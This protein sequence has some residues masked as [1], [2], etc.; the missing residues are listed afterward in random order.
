MELV[1]I[2]IGEIVMTIILAG[3]FR[4]NTKTIKKIVENEELDKIANQ[5]PEN[6]E[7]CQ[8]ILKMLGNE[9]V[10]MKENENPDRQAS[11][12]IAVTDTIWIANIKESYTRIQTI[13]HECLHSIQNRK[14]LLFNFIYSNIYLLYFVL[15]ILLTMIGVFHNYNLQIIIL[16]GLGCIYYIV[17][18]YLETDA[19]TKA[20]FLAKTYMVEYSKQNTNITNQQIEALVESY[21]KMNEIGIP[22]TLFILFFNSISKVGIYTILAIILTIFF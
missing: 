12:Y 6:K 9:K 16:I 22:T 3:L 19:M 13:A 11:L 8:S 21:G 17:R 7:I 2:L 18:S 5:F 15:S 14:M 10:N 20:K 4:T 1:G